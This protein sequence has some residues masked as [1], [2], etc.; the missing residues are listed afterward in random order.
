M[1]MKNNSIK[2]VISSHKFLG[3]FDFSKI[4]HLIVF[5]WRKLRRYCHLS[6]W[7]ER[8]VF[9]FRV[10]Q[11]FTVFLGWAFVYRF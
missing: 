8:A 7:S 1:E 2:N 6:N 3:K 10:F 4:K 9:V 5:I 11:R